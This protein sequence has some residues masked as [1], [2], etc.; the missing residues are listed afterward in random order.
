LPTTRFVDGIPMATTKTQQKRGRSS[1]SGARRGGTKRA[2]RKS[3]KRPSSRT[4]RTATR[5]SRRDLSG[6][7]PDI[8]GAKEL[9]LQALETELGGVQVYETAVQCAVNEDL[10]EE[11]QEYLEQTRHHVEVVEQLCQQLGIDAQ[12]QTPGRRVVNAIGQSLVQAMQTAQQSGE[13]PEEAELVAAECVTLAETKDHL[14]WTLLS[15][16]A[17]A[18]FEWADAIQ[19]AVDE[20]EDEEDEHLYHTM[21]WARE[22]WIQCLGLPAALP[23]PEEEQDV[24][25]MAQ[26]A[27][28]KSQRKK[29]VKANG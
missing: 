8:E 10:K 25:S 22:L 27:K 24:K 3:S 5:Q 15:E 2:A 19:S 4:P 28:A 29:F 26:A 14:N 11:W 18:D 7:E 1:S 13:E 17:D 20:V 21:G 23:P 6:I 9:I 12:E 16:L